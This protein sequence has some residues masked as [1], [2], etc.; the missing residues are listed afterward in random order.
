LL[1]DDAT[2]M[3]LVDVDILGGMPRWDHLWH[4]LTWQTLTWR[5]AAVLLFGINDFLYKL[6]NS[7]KQTV[8]TMQT[9]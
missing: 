6:R 5:T 3:L 9:Y 4:T 8:R 2:N 7:S 1:A